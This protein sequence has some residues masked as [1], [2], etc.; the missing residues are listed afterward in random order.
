MYHPKPPEPLWS[1]CLSKHPVWPQ[2][3][4]PTPPGSSQFFIP[5]DGLVSYASVR[6][7]HVAAQTGGHLS[8]RPNLWGQWTLVISKGLK[9]IEKTKKG[10][11]YVFLDWLDILKTKTQSPKSELL[12]SSLVRTRRSTHSK[13][14]VLL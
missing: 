4:I 9:N 12:H 1:T 5:R 8:D 2:F 11:C 10:P 6:V 7:D 13:T 14:Y 3:F